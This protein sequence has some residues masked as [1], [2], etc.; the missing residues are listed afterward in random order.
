MSKEELT[1]QQGILC[2]ADQP[3][4]NRQVFRAEDLRKMAE[5]S[6]KTLEYSDEKLRL[7]QCKEFAPMFSFG[8][9]ENL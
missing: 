6:H 9:L 3:N 4:S 8:F 1:C 2:V 5:E 7:L